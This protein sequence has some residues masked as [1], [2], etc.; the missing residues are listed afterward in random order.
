MIKDLKKLHFQR[1]WF[2][3][4]FA[5]MSREIIDPDSKQP[6]LFMK[7]TWGSKLQI[8][9]D[10]TKAKELVECRR[11]SAMSGMKWDVFDL[12]AQEKK[13]A[14]IT[15]NVL[16]S[17]MKFGAESWTVEGPD[18]GEFL[19]LETEGDSAGK[20]ILDNM[21]ALY[22][23]THKYVVKGVDGQVVATI[24]AKHGMWSGFYDFSFEGGSE[25]QKKVALALFAAMLLMLKK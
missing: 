4:I 19:K 16:K 7:M 2:K 23:P 15:W 10:K 24:A 20:R 22:N 13:L 17:A 5:P 8:F 1:N 12:E 3:A 11:P 25:E 6:V 18:G 14:T 21:T 9:T